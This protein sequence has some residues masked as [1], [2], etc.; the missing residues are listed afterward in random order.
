MP[1]LAGLTC[2]DDYALMV[3]SARFIYLAGQAGIS[4]LDTRYIEGYIVFGQRE[5]E[6]VVGMTTNTLFGP[7]TDISNRIVLIRLF[8]ER[9]KIYEVESSS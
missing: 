5:L 7:G 4:S 1:D 2:F 3:K 8:D 9:G 6:R